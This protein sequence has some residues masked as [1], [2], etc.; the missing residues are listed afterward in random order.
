MY[1]KA[2]LPVSG[3]KQ[4]QRA[5]I[6]LQ[7]ARAICDGEFVILHVTEP[8]PQ[9]V[10][11]EAREELVRDHAAKGLIAMAPIIEMLENDGLNF[12]TRVE[13]GTPV[14]TIV[15]VANEEG[16]D[17]VVMCTDG[18][19]DLGDV[20]FGSVTERVLRNLHVDLLAVRNPEDAKD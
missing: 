9:T 10:G 17:I 19:D 13:P 12:H 4:G 7:K 1:K 11:G 16:A 5:A 18:R 20:V 14:E 3:A 2:L 8:V 15:K 6:A